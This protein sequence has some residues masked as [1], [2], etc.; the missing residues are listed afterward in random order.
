[1][2]LQRRFNQPHAAG[3]IRDINDGAGYR[4]HLGFLL[5]PTHISLLTNTDGVAVSIIEG[6]HL[7]HVGCGER[8]P[9]HTVVC[10]VLCVWLKNVCTRTEIS[11]LYYFFVP[12]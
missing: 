5:F 4:K 10:I 7:A 3:L 1:M 2:A 9:T 8:A 11:W 12:L 6:I